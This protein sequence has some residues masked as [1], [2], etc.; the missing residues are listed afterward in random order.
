MEHKNIEM[1]IADFENMVGQYSRFI[2]ESKNQS[3]R[4][5][6]DAVYCKLNF[7][8]VRCKTSYPMS[9]TFSNEIDCFTFFRVT[10]IVKTVAIDR[11][12][13]AFCCENILPA[14]KQRVYIVEAIN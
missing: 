12:F 1:S 5:G 13:F 10:K 11:T 8:S 9:V 6:N 7:V 4:N 3:F 14:R 2:Y